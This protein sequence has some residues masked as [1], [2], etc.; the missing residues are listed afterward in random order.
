MIFLTQYLP[1][2]SYM[3]H[4]DRL[5]LVQQAV[6]LQEESAAHCCLQQALVEVQ[7]V[8]VVLVELHSLQDWTMLQAAHKAFQLPTPYNRRFHLHNVPNFRSKP[9]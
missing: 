5:V 1:K 9:V 7:V 8:T 3:L 2:A 6:F 4:L